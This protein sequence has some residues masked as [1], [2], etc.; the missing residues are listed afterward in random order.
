M[1][2]THLVK[3]LDYAL[4]RKI[5]EQEKGQHEL[6]DETVPNS[7]LEKNL[8]QGQNKTI[9]IGDRSNLAVKKC[10]KDFRTSSAMAEALKNML[11]NPD[12]V[13]NISK[14]SSVST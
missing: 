13:F 5:R 8:S 4:L 14:H 6:D 12:S 9:N 1:E 2:H 11:H 3:G 7:N 10:F